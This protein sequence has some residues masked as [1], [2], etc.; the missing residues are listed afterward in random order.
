MK[1]NRASFLSTLHH[2]IFFS[3]SAL[4]ARHEKKILVKTLAQAKKRH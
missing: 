4:M 3:Y 1:Y 2:V